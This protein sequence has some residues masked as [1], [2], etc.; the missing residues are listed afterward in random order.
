MQKRLFIFLFITGLVTS[1]IP[2][3]HDLPPTTGADPNIQVTST[4][5]QLKAL[6]SGTAMQLDDSLVISGLV[7][8]DDETGNFYKSIVIQDAT[9]GILIRLDAT[10]LFQTYPVG[11]RLFI[12]L[13]GLW[14][15]EYHGLIQIG[16]SKTIGTINEVDAIPSTLFDKVI[17]KGTLNNDVIPVDVN[18]TSLNTSHQNMLIRL[19][20]VQFITTDTG[21]AYAPGL[22]ST[23]RTL[24]DCSANPIIVR[25][26]G[27]ASFANS[28]T[29]G[30]NGEF[31]GIYSEYGTT[32]QL[33]IRDLPDLKMT[34]NRC[35]PYAKK[36]F[37]DGS[38]TSG[39]W[40]VYQVTDPGTNWATG[41][42]SPYISGGTTYAKCS[43]YYASANHA[44]QT[45]LISP[46]FSLV[47]ATLPKLSFVNACNYSGDYLEAKVCST[48]VSGDPTTTTWTNLT[49]S[50]S[51]GSWS[52]VSSGNIDL[53]A[54]NG[55]T[56]VH[57]ALIYK[58][59]AVDGRTWEVDNIIVQ[60]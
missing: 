13:G 51:T 55:Q 14:M 17:L 50:Y 18:I 56:N 39:G 52:W 45:W 31:V 40:S 41:T 11:R 42:V 7:V 2:D 4:I 10:N 15:G 5:A 60:E 23:N 59:T 35:G 1:C 32:P 30:R 12:K 29:P 58:G 16:S 53:S 54:F 21:Q 48:Y 37:E 46:S 3:D 44:A 8:A 19:T 26:S 47:G 43:N 34:G 27:Y 28:I 20:N 57:V 36:D 6:Y 25:T 38:I 33:I 24:E 9:A 49:F 22:M